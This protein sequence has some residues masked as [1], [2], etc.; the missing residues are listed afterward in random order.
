MTS[1]KTGETIPLE[2]VRI[3]LY[4]KN[5]SLSPLVKAAGIASPPAGSVKK[6]LVVPSGPTKTAEESP[7]EDDAVLS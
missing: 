6:V 7:A 2:V 3:T 5:S 1:D 4:W